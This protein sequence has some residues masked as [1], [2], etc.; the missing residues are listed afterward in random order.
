[1][2]G[3]IEEVTLN[4]GDANDVESPLVSFDFDFGLDVCL[5]V[6]VAFIFVFR[7]LAFVC[8]KNLVRKIG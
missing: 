2:R 3:Q 6:L 5:G 7:V 4:A 8:L 1:M